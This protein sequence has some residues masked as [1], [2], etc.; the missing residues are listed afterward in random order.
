MLRCKATTRCV[1]NG[2]HQLATAQQSEMPVKAKVPPSKVTRVNFTGFNFNEHANCATSKQTAASHPT[3]TTF[4]SCTKQ[5]SE[6]LQV[7]IFY[8]ILLVGCRNFQINCSKT[9]SLFVRWFPHTLSISTQYLSFAFPI[10]V[11]LER[12]SFCL[13]QIA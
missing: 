4:M 6:Q 10:V 8:R 7:Q 13:S 11:Q 2:Y 12:K 9:K 1:N 5:F 3:R